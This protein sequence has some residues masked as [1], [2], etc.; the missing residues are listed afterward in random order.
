MDTPGN[1][2]FDLL[3]QLATITIRRDI[4]L[5]SF[6][7]ALLIILCVLPCEG[8]CQTPNSGQASADSTRIID[9]RRSAGGI[10]A[11]YASRT[12]GFNGIF[13]RG[14]YEAQIGRTF[15]NAGA[16]SY[17]KIND[18][19]GF[20]LRLRMPWIFYPSGSHTNF[21]PLAGVSFT[22][23][24]VL[25]PT[26]SV[27]FPVGIEYEFVIDQFPNLSVSAN[28]APLVNLGTEKNT[29]IFDLRLGIR[30]D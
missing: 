10:E 3:E 24:P 22:V 11:A 19:F 15:L 4:R 21:S 26:V 8:T 17:R 5:F 13:F 27:G 7:I 18:G 2:T 1:A 30:F 14:F 20:D 29:V 28:A 12:D 6:V 16:F 23:W 25:K 9:Q